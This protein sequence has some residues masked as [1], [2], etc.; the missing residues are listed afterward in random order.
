MT[1]L[2]QKDT[3]KRKEEYYTMARHK[4]LVAW[5]VKNKPIM[6][7]NKPVWLVPQSYLDYQIALHPFSVTFI[8][9]EL[10]KWLRDNIAYHEFIESGKTEKWGHERAHAF[11]EEKDYEYLVKHKLLKK[12]L[13]CKYKRLVEQRVAAWK[14]KGYIIPVFE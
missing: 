7:M 12:F 2:G 9:K 4:K 8:S 3:M 14:K 6:I 5:M 11:A 1:N 13:K 10:P